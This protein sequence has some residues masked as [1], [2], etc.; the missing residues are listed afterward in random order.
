M[1]ERSELLRRAR[2]WVS[3]NQCP[4]PLDLAV[5]MMGAGLDVQTIEDDLLHADHK[6]N[7]DGSTQIQ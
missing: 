7:E 6:E 4:L 3:A 5:A 1:S 2:K